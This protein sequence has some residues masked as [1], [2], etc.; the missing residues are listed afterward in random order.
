MIYQEAKHFRHRILTTHYRPWKEKFRWGLLKSGQCQFI[1]LAQWSATNGLSLSGSSSSDIVRLRVMLAEVAPDCQLVCAKA[2]VVL[3]SLLD[4]L[5]QLYECR[6]PRRAGG[7]YT[8]GD[9]LPAID[10]K[11]RQALRVEEQQIDTQT[12]E[13]CYRVHALAPLLEQLTTIMRRAT[14]LARISVPSRSICW[15]RTRCTLP[16]PWKS[17][18]PCWWTTTAAGRRATNRGAIGRRRGR[19]GGCIR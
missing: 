18:R 12:G 1:E 15:S 19:R 4:Y 11:L 16:R 7:R 8:L 3:E 10:G 2:G 14:S 13:I 9:L 17:W 6:V 5:T